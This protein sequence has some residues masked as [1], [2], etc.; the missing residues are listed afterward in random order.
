MDDV[1]PAPGPAEYLI[2]LHRNGLPLPKDRPEK[3]IRQ[4]E[5]HLAD[6]SADPADLPLVREL[7]AALILQ[8]DGRN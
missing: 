7:L 4:L 8:R 3:M 1:P 6:P 2:E 5:R